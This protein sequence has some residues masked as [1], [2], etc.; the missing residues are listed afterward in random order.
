MSRKI[1]S[2][3]LV[4]VVLFVSLLT[5][6]N[7]ETWYSCKEFTIDSIHKLDEGNTGFVQIEF[8]LTPFGEV[9]NGVIGYADSSTVIA[10][11]RSNAIIVTMG[12][13]HGF[14]N[15][16]NGDKYERLVDVRYEAN[17]KHHVKIVADMDK[18][19]YDVYITP[20]GGK[21]KKIAQDFAF[22]SDAPKTDDVGQVCLQSSTGDNT[23]KVEN[24]KVKRINKK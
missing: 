21:E 14:F 8:D 3:F 17:K 19:V 16:R 11:W 23:F 4:V 1:F 13:D 15:A 18:K 22:R 20:E 10:T 12:A 9:L 5:A 24:H 6:C 2:M 7:K